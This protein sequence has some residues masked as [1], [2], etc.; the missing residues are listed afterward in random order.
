MPRN[1]PQ[2]PAA[3]AKHWTK[4]EQIEGRRVARAQLNV[5]RA[6]EEVRERE[7]LL[8]HAEAGLAARQAELAAAAELH[9]EALSRIAASREG[10]H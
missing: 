4:R 1:P 3:N 7:Q 8:R 9:A 10:H 2:S 5:E 6:Q